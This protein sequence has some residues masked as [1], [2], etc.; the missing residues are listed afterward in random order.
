MSDHRAREIRRTVGRALRAHFEDSGDNLA[1]FVVVTWDMRGVATSTL[2]ANDG[3]IGTS[4]VPMFAHDA[5]NR[6]IARSK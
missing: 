5:L 3:P 2:L 6:H 1:G 4:M